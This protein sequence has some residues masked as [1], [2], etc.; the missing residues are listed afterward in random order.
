MV[1]KLSKLLLPWFQFARHKDGGFRPPT[2][3]KDFFHWFIG[4][5]SHIQVNWTAF[6]NQQPEN[7][8]IAILYSLQDSIPTPVHL[9]NACSLS[10]QHLDDLSVASIT[11]YGLDDRQMLTRSIGVCVSL[12][13]EEFDQI[14]P[15]L[16]NSCR[17]R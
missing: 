17:Q 7:I 4:L 10:K 13:Q 5:I 8:G 15:V 6:L 12:I 11:S 9:I 14:F 2:L 16:S 3:R 1:E